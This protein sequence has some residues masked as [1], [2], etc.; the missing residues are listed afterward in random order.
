MEKAKNELKQHWFSSF[1]R[2]EKIF[3]KIN[4]EIYSKHLAEISNIHYEDDSKYPVFDIKYDDEMLYDD[5]A[6]NKLISTAVGEIII[7]AVSAERASINNAMNNVTDTYFNKLLAD[8]NIK[9]KSDLTI[10]Q[11][12]KMNKLYPIP[13]PDS[14]EELF[15]DGETNLNQYLQNMNWE[16]DFSVYDLADSNKEYNMTKEEDRVAF[17]KLLDSRLGDVIEHTI[18]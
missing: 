11:L 5:E 8:N 14:N 9:I 6:Y 16:S 10:T 3:I 17:F 7:K 4:N 1:M 12:L 15:P 13:L 18:K 2:D